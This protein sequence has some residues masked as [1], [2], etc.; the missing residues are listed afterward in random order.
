MFRGDTRRIRHGKLLGN[1][2]AKRDGVGVF[3]GEPGLGKMWRRAL[4]K[5]SRKAERL[6]EK[7]LENRAPDDVLE[8]EELDEDVR[9][10]NKSARLESIVKWKDS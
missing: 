5:S 9:A 3:W 8:I 10:A 7:L 1:Q 2:N 6:E 4:H